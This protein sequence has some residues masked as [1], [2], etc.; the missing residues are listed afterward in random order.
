MS[1]EIVKA[2][3]DENIA[4]AR[5]DLTFDA[6]FDSIKGNEEYKKGLFENYVSDGTKSY[7]EFNAETFGMGKPEAPSEI[8]GAE[9]S[10]TESVSSEFEV[11]PPAGGTPPGVEPKGAP[12][13]EAAAL[14]GEVGSVV[15]PKQDVEPAIITKDSLL[16]VFTVEDEKN[17]KGWW[18]K[19]VDFFT[20]GGAEPKRVIVGQ[21]TFDSLKARQDEEIKKAEEETGEKVDLVDVIQDFV[22]VS[23]EEQAAFLMSIQRGLMQGQIAER[24]KLGETPT[25]EDIIEIARLNKEQ[26]GLKSSKSYERFNEAPFGEAVKIFLQDPLEI[27]GQIILESVLR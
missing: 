27:G 16:D 8:G 12:V 19:V 20:G 26:R 22:T 23:P 25:R 21:E 5:E 17:R 24:M 7:D 9:F 1:K 3:F 4:G 11:G 6:Y 10:P 2:I 15:E 14:V 18:E 13:A